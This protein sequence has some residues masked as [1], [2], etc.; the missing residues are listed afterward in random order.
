MDDLLRRRETVYGQMFGQCSSVSHELLPRDPHIDVYIFEPDFAGRPFYTLVT[1]GMSDVAMKVP[2]GSPFTRVELVLYAAEPEETYIEFLRH[3]A[4]IPHDQGTYF[5][6]A[7][8]MTNG[9]PPQP[10]FDDDSVLDCVLFLFS[11][12]EPDNS[13]HERLVIDNEPV[14]LLWVVPVS[15]AECEFVRTHDIEEFLEIFEEREHPIVLD[16]QR[17]SYL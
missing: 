13:L 8:T 12:V 9:Q 1:G 3:L 15:M 5:T 4:H 14:H 7:G 2:P 16:P 17:L 6:P 10:I 11:L